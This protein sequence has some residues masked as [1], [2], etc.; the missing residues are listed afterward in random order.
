MVVPVRV[1]V[2]VRVFASVY[3]ASR[4]ERGAAACPT[5]QPGG[6][7]E[8]SPPPLAGLSRLFL[9]E[10]RLLGVEQSLMSVLT[11]CCREIN[12]KR[13]FYNDANMM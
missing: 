2:L 12:I 5:E 1:R 8:R 6:D 9:V 3:A 11:S 7:G 13:E 10:L 4:A